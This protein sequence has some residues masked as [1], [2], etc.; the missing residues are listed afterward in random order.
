LACE[1]HDAG[2]PTVIWCAFREDVFLIKRALE[3]PHVTMVGGTEFDMETWKRN[4]CNIAIATVA[5]GS[6]VNHFAQCSYGIYFSMDYKWLNFQQSKGRHIR[7]NSEHSIATFYHLFLEGGL[8][9]TIYKRVESARLEEQR[10]ITATELK[11]WKQTLPN[12]QQAY[13]ERTQW[14][15]QTA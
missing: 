10:V 7:K 14:K 15:L 3:I 1:L 9:E 8:D 12:Q 5:M 6:S 13:Q 11:T 2:E 4:D